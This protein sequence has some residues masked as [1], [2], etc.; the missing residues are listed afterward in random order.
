MLKW[1]MIATGGAFGALL[2]FAVTD[3]AHRIWGSDFPYGTLVANLLGCLLIG[4]LWAWAERTPFHPHLRLLLF[5]GVL[6]AFT[7][8]STFSLEALQLFRSGAVRAAVVYVLASNL[9]G[10][11]AAAVGYGLA[12]LAVQA[13]T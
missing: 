9:G 11:L 3:L 4:L 1:I 12:R 2:R 7:T 13:L 5:V 8:F 10:L 6:G